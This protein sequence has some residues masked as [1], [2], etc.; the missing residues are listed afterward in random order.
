LCLPRHECVIC[1]LNTGIECGTCMD[2]H[3]RSLAL[4][5]NVP[6]ANLLSMSVCFVPMFLLCF[7]STTSKHGF[8]QVD[9]HHE[10]KKLSTPVLRLPNGAQEL[11][12]QRLY[13]S[14]QS[15][16]SCATRPTPWWLP[17]SGRLDVAAEIGVPLQLQGD[18]RLQEVSGHYRAAP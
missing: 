5:V 3:R 6:K 14:T 8:E 2:Y 12:F 9:L 4:M 1:E 17:Q 16:I 11:S 15:C 7:R 13:F 18:R 10:S